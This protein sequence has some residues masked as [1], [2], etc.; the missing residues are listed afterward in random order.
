MRYDVASDRGMIKKENQDAYFIRVAKRNAHEM[1]LLAV[2]D[3]VSSCDDGAYASR[4]VMKALNHLF[5][6]MKEKDVDLCVEI[7]DIHRSLKSDAK[8]H[9]QMLGTTLSLIYYYDDDLHLIQVGDSRIYLYQDH[10]RQISVDQT[11]AQMKYDAKTISL[12]QFH[13][14]EERHIL[15]QC[16]G[17][18]PHLQIQ[19]SRFSWIQKDAL[20]LCSDGIYNTLRNEDLENHMRMFLK[21][22]TQIAQKLID[23][24][25]AQEEQ[26]NMTAILFTRS[27]H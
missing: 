17:I 20:L 4:F 24:A 22:E 2:M 19:E 18:S 11:L 12:E 8:K 13:A 6:K 14:S 26:D 25:L 9:K 10:L 5:E 16:M 1:G 23:I 7:M 27:D 21:N 3:G 15:T